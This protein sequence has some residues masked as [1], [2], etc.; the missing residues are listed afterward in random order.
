MDAGMVHQNSMVERSLSHECGTPSF[1]PN[2]NNIPID[3]ALGGMPIDPEPQEELPEVHL[4]EEIEED[5]EPSSPAHEQQHLYQDHYS[6]VPHGDPFAPEPEYRPQ[7]MLVDNATPS[8]LPPSNMK[9][10]AKRKR[11]QCISCKSASKGRGGVDKMITCP[12]CERTS[13]IACLNLPPI[14][15][16]AIQTYD[17]IC[18]DCKRCEECNTKGDEDQILFCDSCDR[19]F[20]MYCLNP[21]MET[22]PADNWYC[23]RCPHAST[24]ERANSIAS[25]SRLPATPTT[26]K[27]KRKSKAP[28]AMAEEEDVDAEG[29]A[30]Y[31]DGE[32]GDEMIVD[33]PVAAF[34]PRQRAKAKKRASEPGSVTKSVKRIR[35]R[36]PTQPDEPLSSGPTVRLRLPKGRREEE[37]EEMAAGPFVEI[38]LPEERDTS[39]T[40]ILASDKQRFERSRA[41]AEVKLKPA[42]T[43]IH[44]S[45]TDDLSYRPLRSAFAPPPQ[46]T[47]PSP[48][49]SPAPSSASALG[50]PHGGMNRIKTIRFGQFDIDTWYNA[51]FPEEYSNIPDGR[52]WICEFCLKYMK[53]RFVANRHRTKCKARSPPGDEIYRDNS[54]S[55]FEVDGRKNKIYCQNLCLLSKMFLDHKSLFYDVEPFLFYV[56]TEVDDCGARFV[57]YFSKEKRC[58]KDYNVSCI[59]TLPV[60][61]RSGWGNMLID[62]SYLLSKKEKR[63]GS[64]EKPL[65]GLG[66]LGYKSYWTLALMRYLVTAPAHPRIEDICYSTS[67][68]IEDVYT[69][70]VQQR[71]ITVK[72]VAVIQ[73]K[74]SPGQSIKYPKGRKNG[75][76][77]RH[78]QRMQ[79][80]DKTKAVDKDTTDFV[81]PTDYDI[82][83]D[84]ETVKTYLQNWQDKHYLQLNPQK[85]QWSPYISPNIPGNEPSSTA[86][87][88]SLMTTEKMCALGLLDMNASRPPIMGTPKFA[89][90]RSVS[91]VVEEA[92]PVQSPAHET[93]R[94]LRSTRSRA[95]NPHTPI[96]P[97]LR[98]S[99]K[100][101]QRQIRTPDSEDDTRRP[102][103]KAA[104]GLLQRTSFARSSTRKSSRVESSPDDEGS[105]ASGPL[106]TPTPTDD[107]MCLPNGSIC[108]KL[109]EEDPESD[110]TVVGL[111]VGAMPDPN[112]K[113]N[114]VNGALAFLNAAWDADEKMV[115]DEPDIDAEG[116]EE[117]VEMPVA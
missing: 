5:A 90:R 79:T 105:S 110:E 104:P 67:M 101:K 45:D 26:P 41:V 95:S 83:W 85:L 55:I 92:L 21:P 11:P 97:A 37:E 113:S 77:R 57:G 4:P 93:P 34:P 12:D 8:P 13:H 82:D 29:E 78:L 112:P 30:E 117:D 52:L 14:A 107:G 48:S 72:E 7:P 9:Q 16:E 102:R 19:G 31:A 50:H 74:P 35:V 2:D 75:V 64:P 25:S 115:V 33:G 96:T 68:T 51:P 89:S 36:A 65:S 62:F 70:L 20:H 60:R 44:P 66:A 15:A 49:A 53:S 38:L 17:W 94:A 28:V 54:V 71:M 61:Q 103:S 88:G 99:R 42:P 84:P 10:S 40:S 116:E 76:A 24:S 91:P 27:R 109:E 58:P 69:T 86:D 81:P 87:I 46:T 98:S 59:M 3:P 39:K 73:V 100:G 111:R 114:G 22:T 106:A 32:Q 80:A 108:A 56:I 23:P 1:H 18:T 63:M 6:Q 47:L 43:P